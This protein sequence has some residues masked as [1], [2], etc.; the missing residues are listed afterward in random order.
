MYIVSYLHC[1]TVVSDLCMY[2]VCGKD[3]RFFCSLQDHRQ[4]YKKVLQ[5]DSH[6]D[7]ITYNNSTLQFRIAYVLYQHQQAGA[8]IYVFE[9]PSKFSHFI[10]WL[11]IKQLCI[12]NKWT[13]WQW[14]WQWQAYLR[15]QRQGVSSGCLSGRRGRIAS[16]SET[17]DVPASAISL[18]FDPRLI[19]PL[20]D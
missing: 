19:E 15:R 17:E 2:F 16:P 13:K 18:Q 12:L 4:Y 1:S 10:L 3:T 14:Q 6:N 11:I 5:C 7:K 8:K 20:L 9:V